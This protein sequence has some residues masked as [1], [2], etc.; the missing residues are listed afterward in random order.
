MLTQD[1]RIS[2]VRRAV[3]KVQLLAL[4]LCLPA[5][6]VPGPVLAQDAAVP[7]DIQ[8]V[9]FKKIFAYVR[10]LSPGI[11]PAVLILYDDASAKSMDEIRKAFERLQV[12]AVG[13][14]EAELA[15][16]IREGSSVVYVAT[17]RGSFRQI[18][19]KTRSLSITGLPLLVQRGDASIGLALEESKPKILVNMP[20][21]K[22]EGHEVAS[23]LLQLAQLIQ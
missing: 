17:P 5:V 11:S 7:A 9:I 20:E 2:C 23:N 13:V 22:A 18:F 16:R 19:Q 14:K 21:L 8:A 10:T 6:L 15:S 1:L 4:G 12:E 3:F